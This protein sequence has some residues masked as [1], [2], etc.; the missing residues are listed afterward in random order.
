MKEVRQ[1]GCTVWVGPGVPCIPG[2]EFALG[3]LD[4]GEVRRQGALMPA[5][6]PL[7][8]EH[9]YP[10]QEPQNSVWSWYRYLPLGALKPGQAELTA[11][12]PQVS[13]I[14]YNI[15]AS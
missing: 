14:G 6:N 1:K 8:W 3:T 4:C 13:C 11:A 15:P 2:R 9:C 12:K 5:S 10:M 7:W